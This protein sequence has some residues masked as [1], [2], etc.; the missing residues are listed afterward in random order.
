M[1]EK[2]KQRDG[3]KKKRREEKGKAKMRE[4]RKKQYANKRI[5]TKNPGSCEKIRMHEKMGKY[6]EI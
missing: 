4:N 5:E 6:G 2:T 3:M 1:E